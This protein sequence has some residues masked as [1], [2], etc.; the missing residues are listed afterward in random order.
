MSLPEHFRPTWVDVNLDALRW[1]LSQVRRLIPPVTNILAQVKSDAYGHGLVPVAQEFAACGVDWLGVASLDEAK[2]LREAGVTLPILVQSVLSPDDAE[3]VFAYDVRPT[4][5]TVAFARALQRA[6]VARRRHVA[7]HL[8]VDTGMGRLGVWHE[9]APAWLRALAECHL[10]ELEGCYTHLPSADDDPA[11]TRQQ[12]QLFNRCVAALRAHGWQLPLVH[13]ANS[14]GVIGFRESHWTMVRPG[15]MLYGLYPLE[16]L[17]ADLALAP[18]LQWKSRIIFLKQV[19]AGRS[20]SYGGT[21]VTQRPTTIAT[22]PVGYGDGYRRQLS[23]RA[24]V[25]IRGQRAPVVGRVCMD[26]LMIDVGHIPQASEGDEVVLIGAQETA[27]IST[28]DVARWADSI[29]YEIVTAITDRCPRRYTRTPL[30]MPSQGVS[31]FARPL[32]TPA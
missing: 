14:M 11:F 6:A 23:N 24:Q 1:N 29:P 5:C 8:K 21:H 22:V 9:E 17:R 3:A 25:L 30:P 7:V 18:A 12:L 2:M 32:H 13:A 19:P 16:S 4:V 28:E 26:H 27:R 20:I 31:A 10:L 15:L